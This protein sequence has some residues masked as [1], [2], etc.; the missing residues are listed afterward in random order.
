ME[1]Q[2]EFPLQEYSDRTILTTWKMSYNQVASQ[3]QDAAGL[4]R[5][6]AFLDH[7]DLWYEMI[8]SASQLLPKLN[9]TGSEWL[10]RVAEDQLKFLSTIRILTRY[11]LVDS[12]EGTTSH[13]M[14]AVLHKWCF[15]LSEGSERKDLVIAATGIV[16]LTVPP[17]STYQ[18][19]LLQRRILPHLLYIYPFARNNRWAQWDTINN[20]AQ[21]WI[22]SQLASVFI[23][24]GK[25]VE[26]E[27]MYQRALKG[28]EKALGLNHTSTLLTVGNLGNLYKDQ[29][30]LVEAEQIYQRALQGFKKALGPDH[31]STLLIVGNLGLLY[32]DQGK[33]VEAEQMYQPAL[34][35]Y[36]KALGPDHTST[37]QIVNNLGI[38]YSDQGKLVEAEQMFQ[39]ALQGF[40]KALGP[41]HTSTLS[42]VGNLGNLYRDQGK[43]V[44]AE[45]IYQRAL[46]GFEKALGSDHT[47]TLDIVNNLGNLYK[48]QGKLVEAGQMYQRALQGK[49]KALGPDHTSTLD[50]V[51][52]PISSR[53]RQH[54]SHNNIISDSSRDTPL[55]SKRKNSQK[56]TSK[57]KKLR[58][59]I[60]SKL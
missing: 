7:T 27:Q 24:Q 4:L 6:W 16:A 55:K 49:E 20:D 18:Y 58:P 36:E 3:S 34:Q 50:K 60:N 43:L 25:L 30:K 23:D 53:L 54:T 46:Q 31:T 2:D 42:I 29:G 11:S 59:D 1:A 22:F 10:L 21:G 32:K 5:L 9:I 56:G 38:L 37:L 48:D 15:L 17:I 14:H 47:S 28:K 40:K 44:E 8:S 57:N 51:N 41:D 33:L 39:R 26:A 13:S 12:T 19:Q 35:G 45:Q 52:N